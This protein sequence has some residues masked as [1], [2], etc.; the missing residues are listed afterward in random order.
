MQVDNRRSDAYPQRHIEIALISVYP[1][2]HLALPSLGQAPFKVRPAWRIHVL[3]FGVAVGVVCSTV[4][5]SVKRRL[6][7][8]DRLSIRKDTVDAVEEQYDADDWVNRQPAVESRNSDAAPQWREEGITNLPNAICEVP[9]TMYATAP[10]AGGHFVRGQLNILQSS[11][12]SLNRLVYPTNDASSLF[13]A[14]RA[15]ISRTS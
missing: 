3:A 9:A 2:C 7:K 4:T 10:V 13:L 11:L 5:L 1:N 14:P 12:P 6:A 15:R 8:H